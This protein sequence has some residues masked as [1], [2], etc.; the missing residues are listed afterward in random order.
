MLTDEQTF[1]QKPFRVHELL[2]DVPLH[3]IWVFH[4][5]G[6]KDGLT[7][8]D[9]E[10]LVFGM[11]DELQERNPAVKGL[12]QLRFF[13]GRIFHWDDAQPQRDQ[14]L[15][16]VNRL[17]PADRARSRVE[18]GSKSELGWVVY[19]FD[20]EW[21]TEFINDTV[22]GF[23]FVG[24]DRQANEYTLYFTIY[25]KPISWITPF[26]MAL[27]DPFR[28]ILIYPTMMRNVHQQWQQ[29]YA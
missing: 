6:G 10:I 2:A 17:T 13:L 18:P 21:L 4:L 15:S 20:N 1:R 5:P 25:V 29:K 24:V 23:A 26:Y 22:Q 19:E 16:Y 9:F 11:M 12:F 14:A 3:D 27:I 7:A 28:R 8:A